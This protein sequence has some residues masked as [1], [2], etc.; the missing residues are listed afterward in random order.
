[1][2]RSKGNTKTIM[3]LIDVEYKVKGNN[4]HIIHRTTSLIQ[5]MNGMDSSVVDIKTFAP[6]FFY[7]KRDKQEEKVL[8]EPGRIVNNTGP[9][10]SATKV[11]VDFKTV[12]FNTLTVN[13]LLGE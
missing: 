6:V 4:L 2:Y 10:D 13:E 8:F 7:Y 12:L 5:Q 1:M 11:H 9:K 3:A